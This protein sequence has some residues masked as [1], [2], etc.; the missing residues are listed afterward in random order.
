MVI[1]KYPNHIVVALLVKRIVLIRFFL[2]AVK[3]M[4]MICLHTIWLG[5]FFMTMSYMQMLH[6]GGINV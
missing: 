6:T 4:T 1:K 3:V 2:D 5:C